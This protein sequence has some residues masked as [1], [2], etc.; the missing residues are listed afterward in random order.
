MAIAPVFEAV[1]PYADALAPDPMAIA[2]FD[3]ALP[4]PCAYC[5]CATSAT[6]L[7]NITPTAIFLS[8]ADLFGFPRADESSDAATHVPSASFQM[9]L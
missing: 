6:A 3:V 4:P 5:P 9:V 2:E 1:G 7:A 8:T